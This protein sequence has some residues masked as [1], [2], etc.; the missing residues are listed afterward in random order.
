MVT[1]AAQGLGFAISDRPGQLGAYVIL[2]DVQAEKP[3]AAVDGLGKQ[4]QNVPGLPLDITD[5]ARVTEC[6]EEVSK[7]NGSPD[8]LVNNA[9]VGQDV[10]P[11]VELDDEQWDRVLGTTLTRTFSCC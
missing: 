11:I 1:G 9:G 5:S 3:Q 2:A 8:I 10:A 6:F 7:K 4:G